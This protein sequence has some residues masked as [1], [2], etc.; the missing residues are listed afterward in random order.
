LLGKE[1]AAQVKTFYSSLKKG[2]KGEKKE[3]KKE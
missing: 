1:K 2:D 3:G